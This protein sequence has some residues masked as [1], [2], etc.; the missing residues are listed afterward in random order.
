MSTLLQDTTVRRAAIGAGLAVLVFG[1]FGVRA[2]QVEAVPDAAAA[3]IDATML[4]RSGA[5]EAADIGTAVEHDP[6]SASRTAPSRR[7]ALPWEA[8]E[9]KVTEAA[10]KPLVL[11]TAVA[12]DGKSFATCQLGTDLPRIVHIGDKL[13]EYTV[14]SITRGRVVFTTSSGNALD[15][16]ALK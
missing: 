8:G 2:I 14:K 11:G 12:L 1:A 16:S 5:K 3:P 15:V 10:P 9:A 6:F 7:Y 13:G 4:S